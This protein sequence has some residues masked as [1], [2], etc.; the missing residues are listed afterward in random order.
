MMMRIIQPKVRL[1]LEATLKQLASDGFKENLL[2]VGRL[3]N[4]NWIFYSRFAIVRM[5]GI[6]DLSLAIIKRIVGEDNV[7]LM[8]ESS[9]N[10]VNEILEVDKDKYKTIIKTSSLSFYEEL[11]NRTKD[12]GRFVECTVDE[13]DDFY[14]NILKGFDD[15]IDDEDIRQRFVP[16]RLRSLFRL[17]AHEEVGV[18]IML[19][20]ENES[21][22]FTSRHITVGVMPL[23]EVR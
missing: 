23:D 1:S 15:W 11:T 9:T 22:V 10:R 12:E 2:H 4:D 3:S 21:S 6:E 13:A 14:L 5:K 19:S 7:H 17:F 8:S 20:K 16:K 18:S